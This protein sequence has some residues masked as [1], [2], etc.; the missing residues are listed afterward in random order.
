M[1]VEILLSL[2]F[3]NESHIVSVNLLVG[4]AGLKIIR[5]S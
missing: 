1:T 5:L 2:P 3:L 4:L